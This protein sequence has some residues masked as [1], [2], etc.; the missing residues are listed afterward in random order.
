M[1]IGSL[2][3]PLGSTQNYI[4]HIALSNC[5]DYFDL[6]QKHQEGNRYSTPEKYKEI[7]FYLNAIESMNNILDYFY[8]EN[9]ESLRHHNGVST[10]KTKVHKKYPELES[11]ANFA[12][13]YK[14]CIREKPKG[15]G[16]NTNLPWAKDIQ[17][18]EIAIDIDLINSSTDVKYNFNW[19]IKEQEE[20]IELAWKF[21]VGYHNNP[22][23]QE[24]IS[25]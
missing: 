12:N 14:H 19:P 11:V 25:A 4:V 3:G 24:L 9:E 8:Y 18:P 5:A 10:F 20:A 22:A 16:K 21:W 7:R 17:K 13:A 6:K 23:P 2:A 1:K 15:K